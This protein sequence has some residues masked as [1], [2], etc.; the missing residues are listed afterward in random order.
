MEKLEKKK[1]FSGIAWSVGERFL[2]QMA[3]FS[4]SIVLARLLLPSDFGL[5]ALALVAVNFLSIFI[6]G[7]IGAALIQKKDMD[8]LDCSTVFI[9]TLISSLIIYAV[10]FLAAPAIAG[11]FGDERIV[12]LVRVL[13][14]VVVPHAL[15]VVPGSLARRELIFKKLFWV[16]VGATNVSAVVGIGMALMGCGVWALAG[17]QLSSALTK[18]FGTYLAVPWRPRLHFRPDRFRRLFHFS[19]NMLMSSMLGAAYDNIYT[20]LIG[21][22]YSSE[23]LGLYSRGE[24][25]PQLIAGVLNNPICNVLFPVFSRCQHDPMQLRRIMRLSLIGTMLIICPLMIGLCACA[26]PLT[27]I[28]LGEKWLPSV[29]FLQVLCL[30][31]I[32]NFAQNINSNVILGLGKAGLVFRLELVR[33]TLAIILIVFAIKLPLMIFVWSQVLISLVGFGIMAWPN[34]QLIRYSIGEQLQDILPGGV[35]SFAMGGC[36][37]L[38][39][40]AVSIPWMG[41]LLQVV[42]GIAFYLVFTCCFNQ[43]ILRQL[44][45]FMLLGLDK[46]NTR[47]PGKRIMRSTL[48]YFC[49]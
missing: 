2:L 18:M 35:I 9:F 30:A 10:I 46:L 14:L 1:F 37:W 36:V 21:K 28:L 29:P 38:I 6:D 3:Q 17:Q 43:E 41:L 13:S 22:C 33:R 15:A 48:E 44:T 16:S 45:P 27:L 11:F 39:G 19:G 26:R 42:S 12:L 8:D 32:M 31:Y 4:V 49:K 47:I 5:L 23:I 34:R 40:N 25:I 20:I 7:G 24:R